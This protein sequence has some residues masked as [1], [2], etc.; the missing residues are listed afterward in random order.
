MR[1]RRVAL[2]FAA[3]F[4]ALSRRAAQAAQTRTASTT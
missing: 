4:L 1:S 3:A 2:A